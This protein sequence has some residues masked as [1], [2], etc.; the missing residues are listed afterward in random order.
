MLKKFLY[1]SV[2]LCLFLLVFSSTCFALSASSDVIYEGIDVSNWQGYID[3]D[4]VKA[5]GIDIVYIKASQG[6][7]ITDP[8]FKLNYNN[9]KANGL[10]IGLY[11]FLT[12]RSNEEAI[13]EAEYF[14][15]VI[16]ATSPDCKLAMDFENFGNLT[17]EQ[18]NSISSTFLERVKEL[19]GKE[20]IIYSDAFNARETFGENLANSYPL[21]IAEYGV[22]SPSS[23][24]NWDVWTRIPIY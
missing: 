7:N 5:S 21:W 17:K 15:S 1:I 4:R 14:S 3:Y 18:I 16:S 23:N 2:I 24:V 22:S 9:A 8:F 10:K 12:A 11:H 6:S 20:V 13:R 19:T